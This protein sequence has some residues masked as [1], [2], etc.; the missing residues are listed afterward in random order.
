MES[1]M[2]TWDTVQVDGMETVY[3]SDKSTKPD[4]DKVIYLPIEP[5]LYTMQK[6]TM[7]ALEWAV[8]NKEFDFI[9][10]PHSCLY[11]NKYE[12]RDFVETLPTE[13]VFCGLEVTATP[14]W[15]WGGIGYIFSRDVVERLVANKV[16][17]RDDLMEDMTLS[18]L[19][20]YLDIPYTQGRGASI[21]DK[22]DGK[23]MAMCYGTDSLEFTD[24]ADVKKIKGQYFY[25]VKQDQNRGM[26]L[27]IMKELFKAL[28]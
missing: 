17:M 11:V 26:D 16:Y 23:W 6:K 22:K 25:R 24:F 28:K 8:N 14:H 15:M 1:S 27:H 2:N 13:N 4:T 20:N 3:Y 19:A 21:E 9:A 18:Y 7:M 12:L 5:S 10:R